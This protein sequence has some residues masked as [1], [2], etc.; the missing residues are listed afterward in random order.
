MIAD[1]DTAPEPSDDPDGVYA[2]W[3]LNPTFPLGQIVITRGAIIEL[4]RAG[5]SPI[6]L[7]IRHGHKDWGDLG[8]ED[9]AANHYALNH[10][11]R[12]FSCYKLDEATKVYVITEWDRSVTTVLLASEY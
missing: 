9:K 7:L 6:P 8:D 1:D 10:E 3:I 5:K 12:L 11:E 4:Q 2:L